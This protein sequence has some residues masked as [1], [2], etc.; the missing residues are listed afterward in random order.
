MKC[1]GH[2]I[3]G[4]GQWTKAVGTVATDTVCATCD[5][6]TFREVAPTR[7]DTAESKSAVCKA[8]K[9]CS[10]GQ[11]TKATGTRTSDTVCATCDAG[12][13]WHTLTQKCIVKDSQ[14][15]VQHCSEIKQCNKT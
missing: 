8:H 10:P 9:V 14:P 4:A 11:S 3:C 13:S 5:A 1:K 12:Y 7:S 15:L 6:G 2:K